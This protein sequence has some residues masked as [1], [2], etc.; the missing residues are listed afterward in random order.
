M[1]RDTRGP[2]EHPEVGERGFSLGGAHFF[3]A[4]VARANLR[5]PIWRA[6][7]MTLDDQAIVDPLVRIHDHHILGTV[8][9]LVHQSLSEGIQSDRGLIEKI[10]PDFRIVRMTFCLIASGL[11]EVL[12]SETGMLLI[13]VMASEETMKKTSRKKITSIIGMIS[14]RA[15]FIVRC[16][17]FMRVSL[18]SG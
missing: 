2:E 3:S 5:T 4:C 12:G 18:F 16:R 7:S 1:I 10:S 15:R 14:M 17:I 13:F 9:H 6:R 8:V 11:D